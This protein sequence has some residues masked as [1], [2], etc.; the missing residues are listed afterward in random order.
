MKITQIAIINPLT[1]LMELMVVC[2]MITEKTTLVDL[3][4]IKDFI[5][6]LSEKIAGDLK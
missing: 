2:G 4:N 6:D 1:L 3:P 5:E